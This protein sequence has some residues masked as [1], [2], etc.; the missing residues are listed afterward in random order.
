[1]F[2]RRLRC[3]AACLLAGLLACLLGVLAVAPSARAQAQ[4][5]SGSAAPAR[6]ATAFLIDVALTAQ[7]DTRSFPADVTTSP[8]KLPHEWDTGRT[9]LGS[10][11]TWYRTAFATTGPTASELL[12][13]YIERVCTNLEVFLNGELVHSGG[14]MRGPPTNNCNHPQLVSLPSALLKPGTNVLDI[15]VVGLPLAEVAT[16]QRAAG[17][18]A[19]VLGRY[20][21]LA[22]LYAR[23][24][25]WQTGLPMGLTAMLLLTG[26]F[27]L[28]LGWAERHSGPLVWFGA[29][30]L[31]WGLVESRLW[32]REQPLAPEAVEQLLVTALGA[33]AACS[34]LFLLRRAQRWPRWM[35]TA[36]LLQ[37][38][39]VPASLAVAG[40]DG[41]HTT[42]QVWS[43]W[44]GA[45]V[46]VA[47]GVLVHARWQVER[48][49][50]WLPALLVPTALASLALGFPG[51]D[52]RIPPLLGVLAQSLGPFILVL[53][54]LRLVQD[55]GRAL[56]AAQD[57]RAV[58]EQ[59]VAQITADIERN[60]QEMAESRIEQVTARERK[61]IAADLHDDLGAKLLTIVHTSESDR[62]ASLARD[63]LEEMRLSVRGLTGRPVRV[64]DALGDW[65][66]EVVGRLGQAGIEGHWELPG[67]SV[68]ATLPSRSYVQATRILRESV[69]N[70]I[71]HSGA[72]RCEIQA[73]VVDGSLQLL[74]RDDG[75]GMLSSQEERHDRGHGLTTMKQRARQLQGQ[76][77]V[78]S[79]PGQGTTIRLW[80]P[81]DAAT[82]PA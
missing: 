33:L 19:L 78:E 52:I 32:V 79:A 6:G 60:I 48:A 43:L 77:L 26:G 35:G 29:L 27:V 38:A 17:L 31:V 53:T 9:R 74:V 73:G 81:V 68:E 10:V 11:P 64:D 58:L 15:K 71:K 36:L 66:A 61:R 18:S 59:R 39:A 7:A 80:L 34:V 54:G 46:I 44:L 40:A 75:R 25:T 1:M 63:A 20:G 28:A 22:P 16:R 12:A 67:E 30:C 56:Q 62:I 8:V 82:A 51:L 23:Q 69:S 4:A 57:G 41:L 24:L 14:R 70:I 76:C 72:R 37:W 3:Q 21:D 49:S 42:A 13:L 50:V 5:E 47:A 55:H 65:R 45:Q 2:A